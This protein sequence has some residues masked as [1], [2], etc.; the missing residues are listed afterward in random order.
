MC[1]GTLSYASVAV[2]LV[3]FGQYE[4]LLAFKF[5]SWGRHCRVLSIIEWQP[6]G[7]EPVTTFG[8]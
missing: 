8:A 7:H 6:G 4:Q 2:W 5:L 3:T 1:L